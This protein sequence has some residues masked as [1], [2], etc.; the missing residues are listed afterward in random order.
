MPVLH[1]KVAPSVFENHQRLAETL[2]RLADEL[3]G[4]R[5]DVTAVLVEDWP[6]AR[7]F[8]GGAPIQRPTALLEIDITQDTNT[9]EEKAAFIEAAR[10]YLQRELG[11]GDRLEQASYVIVRELPATDWGYAGRTQRARRG[12]LAV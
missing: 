2:T 3:L 6:A 9:L 10:V 7:W 5:R 1:L 12:A 11:H 4:K 8:V